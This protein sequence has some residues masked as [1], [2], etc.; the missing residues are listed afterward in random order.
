MRII[1]LVTYH[2]KHSDCG[3]EWRDQT[4]TKTCPRCLGKVKDRAIVR[5]KTIE[6]EDL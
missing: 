1:R 2:F 3:Y 6:G 4:R 5:I